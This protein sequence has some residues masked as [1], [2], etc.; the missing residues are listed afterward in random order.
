MAR[1]LHKYKL[2]SA[3]AILQNS[4]L[5]GLAVFA[6]S[7]ALFSLDWRY[8][9]SDGN[10]FLRGGVSTVG[11]WRVLTGDI[12]YRDFWTMYA[13]GQFYV[14][15]ALFK[16]FGV[17]LFVEVVAASVVS[18][19]AAWL[20]YHLALQ[21]WENQTAAVA[22]AAVFTGIFYQTGYFKRLDSY[23]LGVICLL[24][25]LILAG[26]YFQTQKIRRL[27][28]A[29]LATGVLLLFKHD[30]A[31]YTGIA[32][33]AGLVIH[34]LMQNRSGEEPHPGLFR[35]FG[36]FLL[37]AAAVSLPFVIGFAL[38]AGKPMLQ[39][40]VIFPLTNFPFTRPEHYPSL[41][42]FWVPAAQPI[43]LVQNLTDYL[44]F[45]IPSLLF[46]CG[47]T[48]LVLAIR[49]RD[50]A[51]ASLGMVFLV[52][53]LLHYRAAH[54]QINTH[55]IT[56]T[57]YGAL[58]GLLLAGRLVRRNWS[59]SPAIKITLQAGLLVW[60]L[61]LAAKPVY[62]YWEERS[63]FTR[64]IN[65]SSV[66]GFRFSPQDAQAFEGLSSFVHSNLQPGEKIFIGLHRHDVIIIGDV[67]A[68]FL[69]GQPV[70]TRYQEL[71]PGIADT[72]TVQA[73]IVNELQ[74]GNVRL[75]V[76]KHIFPDEHLE[77]VKRGFQR[78]LPQVGATRLDAYIRAN[79]Q[80]VAEYGP[81][82]VW[83]LI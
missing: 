8:S 9:L 32:L 56:L 6:I 60:T 55:I 39:D 61:A 40:L 2:L 7:L 54:I 64:T 80:K 22:C 16:V 70:A 81:Y 33:A 24:L 27:A 11:A 65:L 59:L 42:P 79:Y 41:L 5:I 53:F 67:M 73:E 18:A 68:Y 43:Q 47:V 20:C 71:H 75:I 38:A 1:L 21:I 23:P 66:S 3:T 45:A 76:L 19:A 14:L 25:A 58:S 28:G 29:G 44:T 26:Q 4:A 17:H 62:K 15:A 74:T 63:A 46:L 13:P 50:R 35:T 52:G 10:F 77:Q 49:S 72:D 69:L 78:H 12:P 34:F 30:V 37:P 57:L 82:E 51:D 48:A 31:I 83:M 36:A